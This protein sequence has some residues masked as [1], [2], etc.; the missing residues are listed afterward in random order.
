M[1]FPSEAVTPD[2]S[3]EPSGGATSLT[4]RPGVRLL[5][6]DDDLAH[7]KVLAVMVEQS[8]MTCK[9]VSSAK[10][11]LDLLQREPMDVVIADLVMPGVS[12]MDLLTEIRLRYP[13][14]VFLMATGVED[15][16]LGVQA[17]RQGADDYLIKPLQMD[18][19]MVCIERAFRKKCLEQELENY[20]QNLEAMVCKRTV[21][22]QS[23]L[24]QVEQSYAD[25]L[26]ALG[27]AIDLHD[28]QTAG[29][30]RRVA[31]YSL[32]I[33]TR[34]HG[35][36]G[37]LKNL[38][39]GAWLHD[40]GKLAI[41]DAILRKPGALTGEERRIIQE[42]VQIGYDLVK[43]IPFL[44]EAA[45]IILTH[46]ERCD[47]S[48]YPRGLKGS[49]IPLSARIFSV[50]D[51]L[52]AMTSDRPYHSA[53]PFQD[54]RNEIERLAGT[55]FDSQVVSVFLNIPDETW[56]AI[57]EQTSTMQIN[58][59]LAGISIDNPGSPAELVSPHME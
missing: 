59:A 34:M 1:N 8:G 25:T 36:P 6:V 56:E 38:A 43:R 54:A 55:Q 12:G 21:Q 16:R 9:A 33:L 30:S 31:L 58:E 46:H 40:I 57:R 35:T 13:H 7:R 23:A 42:H 3:S 14:L 44:T 22:L 5:I 37:Q 24:G 41:P 4:N 2:S 17:M 50:A 52:D 15:V 28:N 27:A 29:H 53:L 51:T 11:A 20:R 10:E 47:G 45:G 48:G 26:D 32:N 39:M 18:L 49:D 19:V